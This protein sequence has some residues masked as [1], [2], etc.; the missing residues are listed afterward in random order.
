MERCTSIYIYT[1]RSNYQFSVVAGMMNSGRWKYEKCPLRAVKFVHSYYLSYY[2]EEERTLLWTRSVVMLFLIKYVIRRVRDV[3][4]KEIAAFRESVA[5]TL[6]W[7]DTFRNLL[8]SAFAFIIRAVKVAIVA[9]RGVFAS[10]MESIV[11]RC[12]QVV[13]MLQIEARGG[14]QFGVV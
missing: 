12:A 2:Q 11:E 10:E 7:F 14:D 5:A 6:W 9:Q 13:H 8:P 4:I 1:M 3:L